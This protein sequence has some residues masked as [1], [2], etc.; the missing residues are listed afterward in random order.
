MQ[1]AKKLAD[2]NRSFLKLYALQ[3]KFEKPLLSV[4]WDKKMIAGV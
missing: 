1:A 3:A 2:L 4:I